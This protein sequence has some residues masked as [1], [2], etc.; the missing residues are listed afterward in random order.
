MTPT[1]GITLTVC[2]PLT[3]HDLNEL[4]AASWPGHDDTSFA[5]TLD[6]SLCWIAAHRGDSL[7]GF[8]NVATDGGVHSFILDTTVHP[9]ERRAGLGVLLVRA[10]AHEAKSR[11][12]DWLHVD[13]EPHLEGFYAQCGFRPTPA[14]LMQL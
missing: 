2:P 5:R 4:F 6:H 13:Y 11:G 7:V 1:S 8:V 10:A 3:D 14:G 12:A 9:A